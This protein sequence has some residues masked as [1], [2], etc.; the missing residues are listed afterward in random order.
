[1]IRNWQAVHRLM[2]AT[3]ESLKAV[4]QQLREVLTVLSPDEVDALLVDSGIGTPVRFFQAFMISG[5]YG[6]K[7]RP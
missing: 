2:G 6:I 4:P 5:W 7:T 1:M 3:N